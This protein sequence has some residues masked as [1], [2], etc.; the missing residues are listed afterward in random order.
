[1]LTGAVSVVVVDGVVAV[2]VIVVAGGDFVAVVI[3]VVAV[4]GVWICSL[5]FFGK[6]VV[7]GFFD[8]CKGDD[9]PW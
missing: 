6:P 9:G 3:V 1:M 5:V 8:Q 4:V 7:N 2:V